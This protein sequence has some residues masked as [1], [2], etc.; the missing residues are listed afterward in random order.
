VPFYGMVAACGVGMAASGIL[1]TC[2]WVDK[3]FTF[4]P[5]RQNIPMGVFRIETGSLSIRH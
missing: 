2:K 3:G 4:V 5:K 1:I